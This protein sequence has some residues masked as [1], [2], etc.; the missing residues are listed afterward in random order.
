MGADKKKR[1]IASCT[2]EYISGGSSTQNYSAYSFLQEAIARFLD[3]REKR[4]MSANKKRKVMIHP[5][6]RFNLSSKAQVI[7][8]FPG[9]GRDGYMTF[10][11]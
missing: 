3:R 5:H 2:Q 9:D 6:R 1:K 11:R 10:I 8:N 7:A 4:K